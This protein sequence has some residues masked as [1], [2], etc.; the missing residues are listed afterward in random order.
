MT[1]RLLV[2]KLEHLPLPQN[3][4][5]EKCINSFVQFDPRFV[6]DLSLVEAIF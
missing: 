4:V 2:R 1:L 5:I 3:L 6:Q